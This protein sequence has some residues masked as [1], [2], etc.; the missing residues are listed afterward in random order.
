MSF[1]LKSVAAALAMMGL[2]CGSAHA[3]VV[4]ETGTVGYG[5]SNNNYF[6]TTSGSGYED[7]TGQAFTLSMTVDPTAYTG[8]ASDS[9]VH[10]GYWGSVPFSYSLTINGIADT[11]NG[12]TY[13]Y[14]GES[15]LSN[16][17]YYS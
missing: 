12:T 11:F 9:Y 8:Q 16:G 2:A 4:V 6:Q 5:Y 1:Q 15:Y 10:Y 7:L 17:S 14:D 3:W 13:Y